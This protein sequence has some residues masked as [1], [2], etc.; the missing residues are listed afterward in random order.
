MFLVPVC[1]RCILHFPG[2]GYSL[3][4]EGT[5]MFTSRSAVFMTWPKFC[6]YQWIVLEKLVVASLVLTLSILVELDG[7]YYSKANR[8]TQDKPFHA[9]TNCLHKINFNTIHDSKLMFPYIFHDNIYYAFLSLYGRGTDYFK[10]TVAQDIELKG[11]NKSI[12]FHWSTTI[13]YYLTYWR[14]VS[15]TRPS[16]GHLYIQFKTGYM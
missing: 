9:F 2:P 13:F 12:C 4:T 8:V 5:Q 16:S 3:L 14:Q 15:V 6:H 1:G 10:P 11:N 7:F